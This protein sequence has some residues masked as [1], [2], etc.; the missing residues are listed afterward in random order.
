MHGRA[1]AGLLFVACLVACADV[2]PPAPAA[3]ELVP[4]PV[5]GSHVMCPNCTFEPRLY[6]RLTATPIVEVIE[7]EGDPA[8]A[9]TIEISDLDTRGANA[10]VELNGTPL[11]VRSGYLKRDVVLEEE[12]RLL[13]RLTGKPGSQLLVRVFQE[14]ASVEVSPA[15][16]RSRIP[17]T[18]QFTAV[19]KDRNGVVI[20]RQTFTWES[21]D[22][23]IAT[24][25][26]ET[27]LS[28][29]TG[30]VHDVS[31]FSYHTIS[32][33]EGTAEIVAHADGAPGKS[34][35]ATWTVVDGFVYV[36]FQASLPLSSDRRAERPNPV[37]FRYDVR[38]LHAM[39]ATCVGESDNTAWRPRVIPIG[40]RQF[41][42]CYPELELTTPTRVW[43]VT[44]FGGF[45][46]YGFDTNVGLYGRY[47]GGGQP[48]GTWWDMAVEGSYQPKDAI[49]ALCMEH[50]RSDAN[51][52]IPPEQVALAAC[53]VRYGIESE[54]LYEE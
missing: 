20:P 28:S 41:R 46:I 39:A 48:A 15:T 7:F 18:Q 31:A 25:D 8:G 36:T 35:S 32:T 12:N 23:T 34:G 49:D 47:C 37:G 3:N 33:G 44:P 54:R 11:N 30:P 17:D 43:Q 38:R 4:A 6:T 40:E 53:I 16:Q 19:A 51:H 52:E 42:Q 21:R 26:S 13:V 1:S 2:I 10:S 50:D 45:Y 9:Y 24:I 22:S 14:V 29:T 5:A 27:G